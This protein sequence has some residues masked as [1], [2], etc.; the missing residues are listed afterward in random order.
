MEKEMKNKAKDTATPESLVR[1]IL[2]GNWGT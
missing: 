2:L 1:S